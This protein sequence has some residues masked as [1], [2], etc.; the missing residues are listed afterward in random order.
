M[1]KK[2]LMAT[3]AAGLSACAVSSGLEMSRLSVQLTV[4]P[5]LAAP[6]DPTAPPSPGIA[7]AAIWISTVYLIG[8]DGTSRDTIKTGPSTMYDLSSLQNGVNTLLGDQTIVAGDY[9]QLRLVVDSAKVTLNGETEARTLFVPSGM[10]TG[11]KVNFSGPLTI[12]PPQVVAL[13]TFDPTASFVVT[14]PTPPRKV[15][16]RPVLHGTVTP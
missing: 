9:A 11:I 13:V 7:S 10:Q 3:L 4:A 2:L 6:S 14:G 8:G 5:S 1:S 16:F 12:Q 15:L